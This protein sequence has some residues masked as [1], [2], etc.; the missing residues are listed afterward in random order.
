MR[1]DRKACAKHPEQQDRPPM[2]APV[3]CQVLDLCGHEV[4][5]ILVRPAWTAGLLLS[6][7]IE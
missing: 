4:S 1:A 2:K 5:S 6:V 3:S 7:R